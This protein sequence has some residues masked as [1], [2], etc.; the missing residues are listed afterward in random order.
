MSGEGCDLPD[1]V[2]VRTSVL[3]EPENEFIIHDTIL[4]VFCPMT[5]HFLE[6]FVCLD[7]VKAPP[8]EHLQSGLGNES[9][10]L[11]GLGT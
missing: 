2:E 11:T 7:G 10:H 3:D 6:N 8:D 1:A 4:D 9:F 5:L